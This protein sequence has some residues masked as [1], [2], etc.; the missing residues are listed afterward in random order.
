MRSIVRPTLLLDEE[1]CKTNISRM[2]EKARRLKVSFRPHFKTH[3]SHEVGRWFR[4]HGVEKVTVSSLVMA[5]YFASDGWEDITVAFPVNVLEDQLI[6]RLA[7]NIRLNLLVESVFAVNQLG[8]K[9][10][11]PVN[12]YVKIDSGYH[13]AGINPS[14]ERLMGAVLS[15]IAQYDNLKFA[16]FLT[17]AGHSYKARSRNEI[18]QIH[19]ESLA[20]MRKIK[21][22]Y[23]AKYPDLVISVGDTP[24]CSTMEDFLGVDEIRPG[25]FV[26]YDITQSVIGSCGLNDIAVCM[27]C[28]VVSRHPQRNELIIYGGSVHFSKDTVAD[29]GVQIFGRVVRLNDAGWELPPTNMYIKSL[30]QEHGLV[31]ATP[32]DQAGIREG[33]VLGILPVHACL[34]AECMGAYRN[35]NGNSVQRFRYG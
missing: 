20:V 1:K 10:R 15:E 12:V 33:D 26:F 21:S 34:A 11:H 8:E 9:I 23:A 24:C 3:Q 18:E 35:L 16:G 17:H 22:T 4:Q 14:D 25:N 5:E 30:S 7:A 19:N 27:A 2:A 28:P 32:E 29:K 13:R 31:H 6:N